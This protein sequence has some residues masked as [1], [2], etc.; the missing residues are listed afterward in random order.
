MPPTAAVR[1]SPRTASR[2]TA[3]I[4]AFRAEE[5]DAL[6][7]RK[8]EAM[9]RAAPGAA[10]IA[11]ALRR[12]R[13]AASSLRSGAGGYDPTWHAALLRLAKSSSLGSSPGSGLGV[14]PGAARHGGP[15]QEPV[16]PVVPVV[17]APPG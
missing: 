8:M 10:E 13:K 3:R 16:V 15:A 17:P 9:R 5:P 11:R 2:L 6:V 14:R 12:A 4:R 1:P 7:R